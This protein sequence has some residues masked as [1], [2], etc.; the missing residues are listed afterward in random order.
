MTEYDAV[1]PGIGQ[2]ASPRRRESWSDRRRLSRGRIGDGR[3]RGEVMQFDHSFA[4]RKNEVHS[5]AIGDYI[6]A[7]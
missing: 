6:T 5:E 2:A 4:Y 1:P 7:D 3:Q